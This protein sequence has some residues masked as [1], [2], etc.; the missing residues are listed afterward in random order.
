MN[1]SRPP[2]EPRELL[3]PIV[4]GLPDG[5]VIVDREGTIR[6]VNPAAARLFNRPAAELV[7]SSFGF[8]VV[9]GEQTEVD[10][11]QASAGTSVNAELRVVDTKWEGEPVYLASLRDI[12]DRKRAEEHSRQLVAEREARLEAE[13]SSQAKSQFLAIMSHEL[14]TPLNAMLGYTDL[15]ELG[16]SGPLTAEMR[17]QIGRI[18]LS[19]RHLLGLVN[20]ILDLAKV[21]AGRLAVNCV[22]ASASEAIAT[23]IALIEPQAAARGLTIDVTPAAREA[24]A[25]IGD[26]ERVRQIMVNLL[27]NAVKFTDPGGRITVDAGLSPPPQERPRLVTD[28]SYLCIRVIDT[29]TGIASDKHELIFDPFVQA[30]SGPARSREGSG[31]GLAIGRRLARLMSGDLTVESEPGNGSTF[32]LW[33]SHGDDV[34]AVRRRAEA[35]SVSEDAQASRIVSLNLPHTAANLE[36]ASECL[37]SDLPVLVERVVARLRTDSVVGAAPGLKSSQLADHLATLLADVGGALQMIHEWGARHSLLLSDAL[38]IQRLVSERHGA[39]RARL[40]WS[41]D[42]V[43]REFAILRE[44][45]HAL[46]QQ[47]T[48]GHESESVIAIVDRFLDQSEFVAVR[49]LAGTG[50]G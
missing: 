4:E 28:R 43:R 30:D 36:K 17:E 33:L 18:R 21:E 37:L 38:E 5:I 45:V 2:G 14:R 34:E 32:T 10:V 35:A 12:T 39:Q 31:L 44:E 24:P 50:R 22:P 11:V 1:M 29:G 3:R 23:A 47:A 19:A 49:S 25:Y 7:G 13:A 41:E 20:E 27:S 42:A 48:E 46:I 8:P 26:E 6:F 40:G 16:L 9:A 15:L